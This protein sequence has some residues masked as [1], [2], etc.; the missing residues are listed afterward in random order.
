MRFKAPTPVMSRP[1]RVCSVQYT[2]RTVASFDAFAKQVENF[3]DVADDYDAD[4][5]V[6]PELLS[7]QL[8]PTLD[9]TPGGDHS[10]IMRELASRHTVAF[11]ALFNRLAREY[12]RIIV[13][14]THPRWLDGKFCNVS[15]I[16]VPRYEPIHQ[17]KLHLTPTER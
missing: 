1:V 10:A 11:D 14:G 7:V 4:L 15:S 13:A 12:D 9:T 16:F 6:F 8:I 5:M 3:V 17:A 2:L